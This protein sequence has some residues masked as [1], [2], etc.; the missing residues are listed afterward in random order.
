MKTEADVIHKKINPFLEKLGYSQNINGEIEYE[1]ALSVGRNKTVFPDIVINIDGTPAFVIDAK[2]I[3]ENLRFYDKQAISYGLLLRTPYALLTDGEKI[4]CLDTNTE[5]VLYDCEL[6]VFPTDFLSKKKLKQ[7]IIKTIHNVDNNRLEEAKKVLSIFDDIRKFAEVLYEC[8]NIIR[9]NEGLTGSDAFDEIAKILFIKIYYEKQAMQGRENEINVDNLIKRGGGDFFKGYIFT[10][11]KKHNADI[12]EADDIIKLSNDTILKIVAILQDYT[13]LQTNIDVKG[14]T[15]EIFLGRTFTGSLGQFFTPRTIVKFMVQ[16]CMPYLQTFTKENICKIIDPSCGSGGF[17]IDTF[18]FLCQA[19]QNDKE[20]IECL[21]KQ[22]I[23]GS[24]INPRLARVA[25][26]NMILHGDGYS[27]IFHANGLQTGSNDFYDLVITN[28]PFGSKDDN[29]AI[30]SQFELGAEK[31]LKKN[32]KSDKKE[33]L[34]EILFVEKCIKI[35]KQGGKIAILL[36]DGILNNK[37]TKYVRDYI[38]K[39]TIIEAVISLPDRS[40]KAS[41][42]NSKCSILFLKK[43]LNEDE[44][45]CLVYMAIAEKV[46]FETKTKNAVETKENDLLAIYEN[47]NKSKLGIY[48]VFHKSKE[49]YKEVD[50]NP[51]CFVLKPELIIDRIDATYFYAEYIY[52]LDRE[53][54]RISN[55]ADVVKNNKDLSKFPEEEFKYIQFSNIDT[56]L[57]SITGFEKYLGSEAP[58]R[59]KQVVKAGDIICASVKDSEENIAI[60]PESLD[61]AIVS[62]GFVVFRAIPPMTSEALYVLLKQRNNLIQVR[63]KASGT[64]MPSI[65]ANDYSSNIIPKL[66]LNEVEKITVEIKK[67]EEY[68]EH[69]RVELQKIIQKT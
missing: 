68:R 20:Y 23:F 63:Y 52:K 57:G 2:R 13:L 3:G 69:V 21:R 24:D 32:K 16:F 51:S 12:F 7:K 30:L 50:K 8:E 29:K 4:I 55:V 49:K 41:G 44:K 54:Q 66:E 60:I 28:P 45:Q 35:T 38:R 18:Q 10:E 65:S 62:T 14:R 42:A 43:K 19:N 40:F 61:N 67:I 36:P 27:G 17:L 15:F 48:E 53:F 46:G 39:H 26:M 11:V 47:Y 5:E 56:K 22:A 33:Q 37:K 64:I 9:D 58:D 25:K 34:R 31:H 59:A 6:S 1:K